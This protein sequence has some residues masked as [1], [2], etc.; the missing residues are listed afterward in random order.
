MPNN[1]RSIVSSAIQM[2]AYISKRERSLWVSNSHDL[3]KVHA[4][5]IR[6]NSLSMSVVSVNFTVVLN[7]SFVLIH[8]CSRPHKTKHTHM[9]TIVEFYANSKFY[10]LPSFYIIDEK[11]KSH[12]IDVIFDLESESNKSI[13]RIPKPWQ[14]HHHQQHQQKMQQYSKNVVYYNWTVNLLLQTQPRNEVT[15]CVV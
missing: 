3:I 14:P 11:V 8:S 5:H 7:G 13:L 1:S 6:P 2:F 12:S 10:M 15:C 9:H 4:M